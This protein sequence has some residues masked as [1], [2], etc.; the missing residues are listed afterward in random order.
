MVKKCRRAGGEVIEY[1]VPDVIDVLALIWIH[2]NIMVGLSAIHNNNNTINFA[3]QSNNREIS[4]N[5]SFLCAGKI[6]KF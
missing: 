6:V 5:T 3:I 2:A 1:K 4:V